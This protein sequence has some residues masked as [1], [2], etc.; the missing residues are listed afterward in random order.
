V[1]ELARVH[2]AIT[3]TPGAVMSGCSNNT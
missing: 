3:L 1:G 2:A